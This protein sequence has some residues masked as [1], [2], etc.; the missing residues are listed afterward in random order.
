MPPEDFFCL[1]NES[2]I[3]TVKWISQFQWLRLKKEEPFILFYKCSLN[4]D[5]F[6]SIDMRNSKAGHSKETYTENPLYDS[7]PQI[8]TI[9][10]NNLQ[11]LLEFL[12]PIH[13]EFYKK[14]HT[15]DEEQAY[16]YKISSY[17]Q[18][19]VQ[20][21]AR[22]IIVKMAKFRT[23]NKLYHCI[24]VYYFDLLFFWLCQ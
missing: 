19:K 1:K 18:Q 10:S 17:R 24:I 16:S 11:K 8:M 23:Q 14:N 2:L 13:Y 20:I 6:K 7:P 12:P 9:K 3:Q 21:L 5:N 15:S 4:E 22:P